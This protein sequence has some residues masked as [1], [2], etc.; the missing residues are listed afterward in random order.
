[1]SLKDTA[2]AAPR[3]CP[4]RGPVE[5]GATVI[6]DDW[7]GYRGLDKLGYVHHRRSQRAAQARGEDPGELAAR[8][9]PG[10]LADQ[11][12]AAGETVG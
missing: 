10:R 1:M 6:T 7:Q 8:D 12:V 3:V 4:T 11:A 2:V 9:A 5:P